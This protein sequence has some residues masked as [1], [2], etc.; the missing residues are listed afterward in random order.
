MAQQV[1]NALIKSHKIK[2]RN[3]MANA[4]RQEMHCHCTE[5]ETFCLTTRTQNQRT[6]LSS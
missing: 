2:P 4:G 6:K 5:E 3:S 1:T